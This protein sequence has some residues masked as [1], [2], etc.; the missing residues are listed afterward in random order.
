M[1]TRQQ[2][3]EEIAVRA[4]ITRGNGYYLVP[5]QSSGARHKVELDSLFPSCTCK[6]FELRGKD[7]KHILAVRLWLEQEKNGVCEPTRVATPEPVPKVK[8]PTYKQNWPEYNRAQ[9]NEKRHFQEILFDL[10]RGIEQPP[11]KGGKKGGRPTL[12]LADAVF[13]CVFK[14]YSTVS[15][16][17][18]VI[19]LEHAH[20]RG[21]LTTLPH[22]NSISNYLENDA[23]TSV[24]HA[25][26]RASSLPLREVETKFAGDSSGFCTSR[27]RRWFD[28]KYGVIRE[29]AEWVKVHLMCGVKTNVVTAVEI[30]DKHA[31]DVSQLPALV[32]ATAEN[33][34]VKE[35]SVDAAYAATANFQAV[36]DVGGTMY[37]PFRK[38]TT[39]A[40]GGVFEKAF[41]Y[42]CLHREEFLEHYHLRSNVES[43]FSMIKAKFRDHVRSK[44][45][46][47]MVNEVLGKVLAHNV[48]CLISA[49]YELKI[50]PVFFTDDLDDP[51]DILP[52]IRPG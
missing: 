43:T 41:H 23:L 24:L 15:A 8:R 44:T 16:R 4:K 38:N 5:S 11:P 9:T 40:V 45:D 50:T 21:F 37:A 34:T 13:A 33:F 42:F 32:R 17:R 52:M 18:F 48:C 12:L 19:D 29:E 10:C 7:C 26:I 6:D 2:K 1:D 30:L 3:A 51:A 22:F 35:V 49:M 25:L 39:G 46:T 28:V 31:A 27:F 36:A 14:I 20:S 47:A